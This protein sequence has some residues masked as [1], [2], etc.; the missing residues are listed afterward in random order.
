MPAT[1]QRQIAVTRFGK[2]L[3]IMEDMVPRL[4]E[5]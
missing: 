2:S 4:V 5:V 3:L 1:D